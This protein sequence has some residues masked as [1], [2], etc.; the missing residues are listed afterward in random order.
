MV[1]LSYEEARLL[2]LLKLLDVYQKGGV[3]GDDCVKIIREM[4]GDGYIFGDQQSQEAYLERE[5][6]LEKKLRQIHQ[7]P[8]QEIT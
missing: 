1:M 6:Q 4:P 3:S 2:P 7:Q 8:I 5:K